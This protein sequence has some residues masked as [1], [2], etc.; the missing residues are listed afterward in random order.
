MAASSR[1][2]TGGPDSLP[3]ACGCGESIPALDSRGRPRH[4]VRGHQNRVRRRKE[5]LED[6]IARFERE[7]PECG[8]GCGERLPV[9]LRKARNYARYPW[10]RYLRGHNNAKVKRSRLTDEVL[11]RLYGTLLGDSSLQR[12]SCAGANPRIVFNHSWKQR[13]W[14]EWKAARLPGVGLTVAKRV[15][16]GYGDFIA[17]GC[18]S[19]HPQLREVQGI[20]GDPPTVSREWLDRISDEGWAWWY[21]DDGSCERGSIQLHTEGKSEDEVRLIADYLTGKLGVEFIPMPSKGRY[22]LIRLRVR[23]AIEWLRFVRPYAAEGM[24]YK[25]PDDYERGRRPAAW[26]ARIRS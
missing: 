7:A 5:S 8:C 21:M 13:E 23:A 24:G 17:R 6:R 20:I 2:S 3:C 16:G 26:G 11:G 12:N 22:W 19:T 4:F 15:N 9:S 14:A 25:F 10:P 18:S 1:S